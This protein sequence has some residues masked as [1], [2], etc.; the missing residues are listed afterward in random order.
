[1]KRNRYHGGQVVLPSSHMVQMLNSHPGSPYLIGDVGTGSGLL[2]LIS[3]VVPV[4]D[5]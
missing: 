4:V 5:N 2:R 3:A 1:M